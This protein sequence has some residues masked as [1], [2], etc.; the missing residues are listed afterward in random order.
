MSGKVLILDLLPKMF[1]TNQ[2]ERF[3]KCN[4]C[5]KIEGSSLLF[6]VDKQYSCKILLLLLV[7]KVRHAQSAK[8]SLQY[9]LIF[10]E[11]DEG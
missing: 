10:Q 4:I 3:F 1:L 9:F 8:I 7:A 6:L 11:R 2:N 5:K